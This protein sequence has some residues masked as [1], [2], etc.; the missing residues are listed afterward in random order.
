MY[1]SWKK[2]YRASTKRRPEMSD[3]W[4]AEKIAGMEIG[5]GSSA[6]TIRKHMKA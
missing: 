6:D 1:E 3:V 4:H 5:K 2:E